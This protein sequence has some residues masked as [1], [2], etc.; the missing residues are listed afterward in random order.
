ML[1]DSPPF[2]LLGEWLGTRLGS[3]NL[4]AWLTRS[5]HGQPVS[6]EP[7][8]TSPASLPTVSTAKPLIVSPTAAG[9]SYA[10]IPWYLKQGLD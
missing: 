7:T 5:L 1:P 2:V 8:T 3:H 4:I 6:G 9:Q 10:R